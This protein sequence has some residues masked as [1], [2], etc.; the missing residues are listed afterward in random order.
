[1]DAGETSAAALA[2]EL[3][4]ELGVTVRVGG[5]LGADVGLAGGRV[6]RARWAELVAGEPVLR[7]HSALRW[8]GADELA[9]VDLVPADRAW[10]AELRERL[11]G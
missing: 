2:R 1:M 10:T 8:V 7:E 5:Q 6:L 9:G 4:E 11:G 3:D